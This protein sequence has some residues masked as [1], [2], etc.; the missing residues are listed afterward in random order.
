[1]LVVVYISSVISTLYTVLTPYRFL[2]TSVCVCVCVFCVIS[3][4]EGM[5]IE[6]SFSLQT[7][8]AVV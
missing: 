5:V 8:F 2:Y 6:Q 3:S 1:M 7:S 4:V